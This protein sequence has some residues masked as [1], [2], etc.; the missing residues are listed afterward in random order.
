MKKGKKIRAFC[1]RLLA[2][3]GLVVTLM[4]AIIG[5]EA[6][7]AFLTEGSPI[8]SGKFYEMPEFKDYIG[9]ICYQALLYNAGVGDHTGEPL[10][11]EADYYARR[12]YAD[13]NIFFQANLQKSNW[14]VR[15]YIQ[16]PGKMPRTNMSYAVLS[17]SDDHI[18][19]PTGTVLCYLWN[20]P[21]LIELSDL[22]KGMEHIN[23]YRSSM[24]Y[25][26]LSTELSRMI[27][28]IAV[29]A[30]QY[31]R[32]PFLSGLQTQA[33]NYRFV[34][35]TLC[36]S[37]VI[38]L[39]FALLCLFSRKAFREAARSYAAFT[40]KILLEFKLIPLLLLLLLPL[41]YTFYFGA[42][43]VPSYTNCL[44]WILSVLSAAILLFLFYTEIR[45]NKNRFFSHSI[46]VKLALYIKEFS[47][48]VP[49]YRKAM[50]I[51][52]VLMASALILFALGLF[53]F[54]LLI[55]RIYLTS[56][57]FYSQ[58]HISEMIMQI[59]YILSFVAG[60]L[61]LI[62]VFLFPAYF[63]TRKLTREMKSVTDKL[64]DLKN[65]FKTAPFTL[66]KGSLLANTAEDI[67][68]LEDGIDKMV[69][70]KN[71]SNK[72]RVEL[73]TN[74]S[75]DL[76]TPL[77]SIINYADL[78]CEEQL[79]EN[80]AGYAASLRSKAYRLK[81]MVQDVF[82]LSK[83]TSGNLPVE[84]RTLD[85]VKLVR[86]TLADME[87]RIAASS[88]TF[89]TIISEEPMLIESDG[90]KLYRIFQNLF[91]NALQYS[92]ENSRVYVMLFVEDGKACAKVKNTS[93]WEIDFTPDDIVERFVRADAARTTEGSGLGLSIV[94]S[95]AEICGGSFSIE[96]DADMFTAFLRFPLI[97]KTE[98]E[99]IDASL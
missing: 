72:L 24:L 53:L 9:E 71:R 30:D 99:T 47:Q 88:L 78:L 33:E 96:I 93:K 97:E 44:F 43:T 98:A 6:I 73:L 67:N 84:K 23:T 34:L 17:D 55:P 59:I 16:L 3:G 28:V 92:L 91:V 76:K 86:Q 87:E 11:N 75:H 49:W 63:R 94:Q 89:K 38:T 58:G 60:L 85:L 82:D 32:S 26:P 13:A 21:R 42:L 12:A 25:Q 79:N 64:S 1:Y 39:L 45:H 46:S 10:L 57:H 61:C 68:S 52:T 27:V 70:Q 29:E 81:S 14:L 54:I 48:G 80:A 7:E 37:S 20:G 77:T 95:F 62:G 83:A 31:H 74:V 41:Y 4:S 90:E 22:Q 18:I 66:P 50:H 51:G 5:H 15:Y 36:I 19:L 8:L 2:I 65:G 40:G 69:E 35:L 56:K